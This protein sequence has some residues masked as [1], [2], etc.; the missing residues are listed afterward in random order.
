TACQNCFSSSPLRAFR[1]FAYTGRVNTIRFG[2]DGWRGVIADD[3]T[4]ENVRLVAF[5][6]AR[7]IARAEK[8]GHGVI[9][10]YD[11]RF[12]SERFARAA[13]ETISAAG[14]P[15]WLSTSPCPSPAVSL[16]VRQRGAA[17]GVM[18]TASHNPYRW[19]GI[20]FK[21]SYGSSALPSIVEQ[22]ESEL[23]V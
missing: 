7:Y 14:V 17:G 6:V 21:A 3:F 2:T 15:V 5:A 20:K 4:F 13:A 22:I 18:I 11:N 8:P 10:G 16:L 19:N 23:A 9:V 1:S 12:G